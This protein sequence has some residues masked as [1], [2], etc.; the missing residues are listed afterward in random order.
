MEPGRLTQQELA[1]RTAEAAKLVAVGARYR[2]Y[3]GSEYTVLH[4]ALL[5]ATNDP[6][7]VYRAEYGAHTI[8]IRPLADWLAT[9][10]HHDSATP[11]FARL[12]S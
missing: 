1:A 9:V 7:V 11:R 4:I 12:P 3:K 8:F 2:H 10:E 6:C 5:E